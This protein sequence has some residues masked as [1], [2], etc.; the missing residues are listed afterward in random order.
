MPHCLVCLAIAK[1]AAGSPVIVS[2]NLGVH[3]PNIQY[4][5]SLA[6]KSPRLQVGEDFKFFRSSL[7]PRVLAVTK[8]TERRTTGA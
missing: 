3:V 5:L 6:Q 4:G 1:P 2:M 7:L 8:K